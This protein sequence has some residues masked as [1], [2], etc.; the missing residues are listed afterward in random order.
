MISG[1][2][3]FCLVKLYIC[4][5]FC[6]AFV[7]YFMYFYRSAVNKRCA[8]CTMILRKCAVTNWQTACVTTVSAREKICSF[9]ALVCAH[10]TPNHHDTVESVTLHPDPR[11]RGVVTNAIFVVRARPGMIWRRLTRYFYDRRRTAV[12]CVSGRAAVDTAAS[13]E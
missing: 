4:H 10:S 1:F 13:D 9:T 12:N 3:S 11:L 7:S 2:N 5:V 8:V 6:I